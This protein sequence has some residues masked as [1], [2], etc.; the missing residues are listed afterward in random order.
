MFWEPNYVAYVRAHLNATPWA[1][2]W[3]KVKKEADDSLSFIPQP[4]RG[5]W[6]VPEYYADTAGYLLAVAPLENSRDA[7]LW[8]A[9]A[10]LITRD[11]KFALNVV[12]IANAWRGSLM[13]IDSDQAKCNAVWGLQGMAEAAEMIHQFQGWDAGKKQAFTSWL[14]ERTNYLK[15]LGGWSEN[16]LFYWRAM[17]SMAVGVLAENTELFDYAVRVFRSAIWDGIASDGHM[18]LET[19][20]GY[21]GIHYTDFA[22]DPLVFIVEMARRQGIDLYSYQATVSDS[23][24]SYRPTNVSLKLAIDYLFKYLDKPKEWP[25]SSAPQDYANALR[26]NFGWA[27]LAFY[28]W[29]DPTIMRWLST[30][31]P[32]FDAEAGGMVTLTNGL[33]SADDAETSVDMANLYIQSATRENRTQGLGEA[34]SLLQ[35]ANAAMK[36]RNYTAAI[37]FAFQAYYAA[38][39]ATKPMAAIASTENSTT[40]QGASFARVSSLYETVEV[41]AIICVAACAAAVLTIRR[42]RSHVSCDPVA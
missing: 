3:S 13:S 23:Y 27:E 34:Q 1:Y 38:G 32:V 33:P 35:E 40:S 28:Y 7:M 30:Q 4:I 12:R 39:K 14:V 20:R 8:S 25:W 19:A 22:I 15:G 21:R 26:Y 29:R 10:Y 18:P 31:R 41:V 36:T 11:D 16:N 2:A 17:L 5:S 9:D 37:D 42:R 24:S 6:N